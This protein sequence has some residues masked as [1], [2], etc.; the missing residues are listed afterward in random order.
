MQVSAAHT[1]TAHTRTLYTLVLHTKS[2][3]YA[4][5]AAQWVAWWWVGGGGCPF[6][7]VRAQTA[8]PCVHICV[9]R[10]PL[11]KRMCVG[12]TSPLTLT[13]SS[14]PP[15]L[16]IFVG[17][18]RFDPFVS[19]VLKRQLTGK[20]REAKRAVGVW[21]RLVRREPRTCVNKGGCCHRNSFCGMHVA[22]GRSPEPQALSQELQNAQ[23]ASQNALP[24]QTRHEALRTV[25]TALRAAHVCSQMRVLGVYDVYAGPTRSSSA[26][27][28]PPLSLSPHL[29]LF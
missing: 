2:P 4:A 22:P 23:R 5:A 14:L 16:R 29:L 13:S 15:S 21:Q 27:S 7:R 8:L 3:V 19:L 12:H 26:S 1:R 28:L 24:T 25:Q 18:V 6:T 9:G 20:A 11:A 17:A 10:R